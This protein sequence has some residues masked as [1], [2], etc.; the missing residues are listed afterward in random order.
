MNKAR[1]DQYMQAAKQASDEYFAGYVYG[2]SRFQYGPKFGKPEVHEEMAKRMDA[3]GSGYRD[4]IAGNPPPHF[5]DC[6]FQDNTESS[7]KESCP[8]VK[9]AEGSYSAK[10][11]MVVSMKSALKVARAEVLKS[12]RVYPIEGDVDWYGKPKDAD[13]WYFRM[14]LLGAPPKVGPGTVIAVSKE[15]GAVLYFGS[16]HEE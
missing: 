7:E 9:N 14:E 13:C 8:N 5:K 1:F 16:D 12:L 4:G 6:G 11:N 2:L 10:R 3:R 15:T